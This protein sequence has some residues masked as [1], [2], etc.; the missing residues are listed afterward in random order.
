MIERC[1][2]MPEK[3]PENVVTARIEALYN[4]YCGSVGVDIFTQK[5]DGKITAVFGGMDGSYSLLT[6]EG[7]DFEELNSYFSF[8]SATVFCYCDTAESLNPQSARI[9]EL[10]ELFKVTECVP[11]DGHGKVSDVYS[12]LKSGEDG[13]I[14]LPPFEYWYTD[15]CARF[16]HNSA[17]YALLDGAVAVAGFVTEYCTLITGVATG[18]DGRRS[19][20]G[21]RALSVLLSN[22]KKKHPATRVLAAT[23]NAGEFYI[24][25][26]FK[27]IEN[28]A[29]LRF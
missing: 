20:R 18:Y 15:F 5:I 6:S 16:N 14:A 1:K 4:V 11:I 2:K 3:L 22:I 12:I 23:N 25:N 29:V 9:S 17:E 27:R 21:S 10:Y 8:L 7:A 24:K 26:G 28:V 13:D 19:G